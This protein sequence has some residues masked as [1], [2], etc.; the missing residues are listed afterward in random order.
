[1]RGAV[2]CLKDHIPHFK[3]TV[4]PN[5]RQTAG[6]EASHMPTVWER[7]DTV[8]RAGQLRRRHSYNS[9]ADLLVNVFFLVQEFTTVKPN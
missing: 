7:A 2:S 1:M 5:T 3:S 4:E 9:T 6:S 8:Y